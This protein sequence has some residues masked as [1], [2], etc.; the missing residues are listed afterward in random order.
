MKQVLH[1]SKP[2]FL[3][4]LVDIIAFSLLYMYKKTFDIYVL[5]AGFG[6]SAIICTAHFINI[7][8]KL[9]DI[10]IF[11]IV[12]MLVSIGVIMLYRLDRSLGLKQVVWFA[13]GVVLL[14]ITYYICINMKNL[15]KMLPLYGIGSLFLYVITLLF[16]RNV[17]GATN[18][19]F[20]GKLSIQPSEIIKILFV[21]FIAS[22]Y[23]YPK[24]LTIEANIAGK[25]KLK[26]P[27][28]YILNIAVF[29]FMGFLVLQREWGTTILFFMVFFALIYIY[30]ANKFLLV[31][32]AILALFG[33]IAG[34]FYLY[35]IKVR[36]DT[37]L[38]PWADIAGKGYQI[39]QSLFAMGE[40][41]FFGTGIGMGH[42]NYIPEVNSDFIFSAICEEMGIFGGVAVVMLYL[43][44]V[45][46][47]LKIAMAVKD[48]FSKTVALG[49]TIMFGFQTFIIVGGVIKL[50]PL[51]GIT[52]PFV[53]Y[54]GS[55]LTSSFIAI[56]LLLAISGGNC[57]W[58]EDAVYAGRQD[59]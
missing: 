54:G 39:T 22:Y 5:I 53:S 29:A 31:A 3:I 47:G 38:N 55:S 34:Y 27:G 14:F 16:G 28:K 17:K 11:Q 2:L 23:K 48:R 56:G 52:L 49:L 24:F 58:E 42:P 44:L 26:I 37:W 45:Y 9:G 59:V 10:Y 7:K 25:Y 21:L 51:T 41:G 33:C 43:I 4:V 13:I 50:I 8:K 32:N 12:S 57:K 19:I 40:G 1:K 30:E 35:H 6:M 46:R 20:I 18:W 15:D 36:V